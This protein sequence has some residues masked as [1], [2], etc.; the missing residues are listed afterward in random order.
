MKPTITFFIILLFA[1]CTTNVDPSAAFTVHN[2]GC[3][4]PCEVSF[5]STAKNA[6]SYLWE[7]GDGQTA[8]D[9]NPRQTYATIGVYEVTLTANGAGGSHTTSQKIKI[10][11][12]QRVWD[13]AFGGT[14][15]ETYS[16]MVA[17][18][19]GGFLLAGS[20]QL[21]MNVSYRSEVDFN[22]MKVG[23]DGVTQ[24]RKTFGGSQYDELTSAIATADGGFLLGGPRSH[25][26]RVI[27]L[28]P[29]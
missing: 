14:N 15:K 7:F 8:T 5:T 16:T 6:T 12:Y 13:K 29:E 28:S 25:R 23:A 27:S 21:P 1:T 4:A 18:A 9:P 2:N 11:L 19:D 22:V 3:K 24:W 26:L 10:N 20:P 17:T